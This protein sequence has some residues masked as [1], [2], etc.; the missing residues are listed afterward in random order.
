M[1]GPNIPDDL[2]KDPQYLYYVKRIF[3]EGNYSNH[4]KNLACGDKLEHLKDY[5]FETEGYP[6]EMTGLLGYKM[7]EGKKENIA[8]LKAYKARLQRISEFIRSR[9]PN[10]AELKAVFE[11][12]VDQMFETKADIKFKEIKKLTVRE[13]MLILFLGEVI[14]KSKETDEEPYIQDTEIADLIVEYKYAYHDNLEEYVRRTADESKKF[15]D[16]TSQHFNEWRELSTIY[17]ENFKHILKHDIFDNL[18]KESRNKEKI[19]EIFGTLLPKEEQRDLKDNQRAN[20]QRTF[21]NEKIPSEK[22]VGVLTNQCLDIFMANLKFRNDGEKEEYINEIKLIIKDLKENGEF[23]KNYFFE[24]SVPQLI[25]LRQRQLFN[26]N[27]KLEN[28]FSRDINQINKEIEKFEEIVEVE[29]KETQMGGEKH[30][31]IEKSAK[32]RRIRGHITKTKES[33]NARMGAYLCIADDPE[34]WSDPNYFELVMKDE[35]T[36]KCVGLTMYK[37]IDAKDGKKYLWFGPNPFEGFL[38]QVSSDICYKYQ[39]ERAVKFAEENNFDGVVIPS[40]DGQILGQC[41]N[42]G[43]NFPDL[44]KGS[45]LKNVDGSLKIVQFGGKHRLGIYGGSAYEYS[46]GALIWEKKS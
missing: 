9:G 21:E 5:K 1:L 41:T 17:G 43:G 8:Q 39:Y 15:K 30:K 42:R 20:L 29:A 27:I 2:R 26:L 10:N 16:E 37:K 28:L 31:H 40:E 33:A 18:T 36:G 44:I 38:G 4:E 25:G 24:H 35:E 19:E 23:E 6:T 46:D 14:K 12:K 13:Q 3:P 7:K 45:R 34:M 11:K 22:K 32:K